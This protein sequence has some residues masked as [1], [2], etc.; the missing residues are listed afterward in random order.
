MFSPAQRRLTY[1]PKIK[2]FDN[3]QNKK[4]ASECKEF[5]KYQGILI[6]NNSASLGNIIL[7]IIIIKISRTIQ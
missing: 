4:V 2:K 5:V 1:L 6:D 7:I 3:K